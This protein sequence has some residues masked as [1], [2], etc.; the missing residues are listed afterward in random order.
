[1]IDVGMLSTGDDLPDIEL[2]SFNTSSTDRSRHWGDQVHDVFI[3]HVLP[4]HAN[5]GSYL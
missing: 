3:G 2:N 5:I 1:M 4:L